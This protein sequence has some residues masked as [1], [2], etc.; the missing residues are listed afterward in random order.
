[1]LTDC[2]D[3]FIIDYYMFFRHRTP[4]IMKNRIVLWFKKHF[5]SKNILLTDINNRIRAT[6]YDVP[7]DDLQKISYALLSDGSYN[8]RLL[9]IEFIERMTRETIIKY[10]SFIDNSLDYVKMFNYSDNAEICRGYILQKLYDVDISLTPYDMALIGKYVN[11]SWEIYIYH[12]NRRFAFVTIPR[13]EYILSSERTL[14][15]KV[16]A[17]REWLKISTIYLRFPKDIRRMIYNILI[18]LKIRRLIRW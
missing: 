11:S 3:I 14:Y 10:K 4:N 18:P 5:G 6:A 8:A 13:Y 1:M 7:Y 9:A 12:M 15:N 17:S 16:N 2:Q